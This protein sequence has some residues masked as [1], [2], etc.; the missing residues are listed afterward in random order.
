MN[1]Q[2]GFP[3]QNP[4]DQNVTHE[5]WGFPM[6]FIPNESQISPT[7]PPLNPGEFSMADANGPFRIHDQ[8]MDSPLDMNN[9]VPRIVN[10]QIEW[11]KVQIGDNNAVE[12]NNLM[13]SAQKMNH[14]GIKIEQNKVLLA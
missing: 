8:P 1:A 12:W 6:P 10:P 5:G 9:P 11:E 13:D 2:E 4:Q 3:I 14:D 7:D